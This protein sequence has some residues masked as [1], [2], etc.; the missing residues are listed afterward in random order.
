MR[1][2][3]FAIIM[4]L[5][6]AAPAEAAVNCVPR[7]DGVDFGTTVGMEEDVVS[8]VR[9]HCTGNG[10][11]DYVLILS[12]GVSGTY[13]QRTMLNGSD[14]LPYNLFVNPARTQI[15]GDGNGGSVT[16]SG[17]ISMGNSDIKTVIVSLYAKLLNQT[18]LRAGTYTDTIIV[19]LIVEN[20]ITTTSFPVSAVVRP[21]CTINATGL[22]FGSYSGEQ[23]NAQSQISLTCTNGLPWNVG[24]NAGTYPGATVTTRRMTGPG[25][26]TLAYSLY[27]DPARTLNWGA[28]VGT[29][30]V[31]GAG[32][33]LLQT[34]NVYGQVPPSQS[35]LP[36]GYKDTIIATVTF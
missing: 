11:A 27:R 26:S 35:A 12:T 17:E 2:L 34:V 28:S 13:A 1:L 33:G 24:L 20:N 16:A 30:T 22:A 5:L 21:N 6:N 4:I 14:S 7:S 3:L 36:G 9:L 32:S 29:D 8:S 31:S 15:L 18:L 19:N 23:L 25:N 10:N